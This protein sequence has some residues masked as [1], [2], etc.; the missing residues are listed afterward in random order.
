MGLGTA[1]AS[2]Q[3]AQFDG[4]AAGAAGALFDPTGKYKIQFQGAFAAVEVAVTDQ[5]GC[6]SDGGALLS[7]SSNVDFSVKMEGGVGVSICLACCTQQ[8]AFFSHYKLIPGRGLRGD[9][10]LAPAVPGEIM[11]LNLDGGTEWILAK[12]TF[13]A[14]DSSVDIGI[15]VQSF[16]QGCCSGEGFFIMKASGR[17]RLILSSYGSIARYDLQ[18]GEVRR[19]DNGYLVAWSANMQYKIGKAARKLSTSILSGEGFMTV[20]TGP[21]TV[22]VQTRSLKALADALG[23]PAAQAAASASSSG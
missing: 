16:A 17:G 12:G 13:L 14:C 20:F 10:L 3:G 4:S 9:I 11:L 15:K 23:V 19:I 18:A 8:T 22:F 2:W 7:L 1:I 21:G 5:D 6:K